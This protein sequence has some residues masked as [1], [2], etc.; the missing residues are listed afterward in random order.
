MIDVLERA[1]PS[2]RE[3]EL[4]EGRLRLDDVA[5]GRRCVCENIAHA[6]VG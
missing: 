2:S 5:V 4:L 6:H 3:V 1:D